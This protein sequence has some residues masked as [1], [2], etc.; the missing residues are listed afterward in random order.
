MII[1]SDNSLSGK[2]GFMQARVTI[3]DGMA[4]ATNA[5]LPLQGEQHDQ[6]KHGSAT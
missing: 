6:E 4:L 5:I 3:F 2:T 1:R